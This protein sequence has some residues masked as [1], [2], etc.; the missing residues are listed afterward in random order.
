MV[1]GE[2][3]IPVKVFHLIW[4]RLQA[5]AVNGK[6]KMQTRKLGRSGIEVSPMGMVVNKR[7]GHP[8]FPDDMLGCVS[9][10]AESL[11]ELCKTHFL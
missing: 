3:L 6:E 8:A 4:I 10:A 11:T 9:C 1:Q 7:Y 2:G 5:H